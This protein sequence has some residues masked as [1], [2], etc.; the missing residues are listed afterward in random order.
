MNTYILFWLV[1]ACGFLLLE[2]TSPGLFYFLSFSCGALCAALAGGVCLTVFD[3]KVIF[4]VTSFGALFV[5]RRWVRM[6]LR[7]NHHVSNVFALQGKRGVVVKPATSEHF[8]YATIDSETWAF[9]MVHHQDHA[10]GQQI[11]VV[12]IKGAHLIVRPIDE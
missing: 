1:V 7:H 9:K 10:A 6:Q 12:A 8:G 5:L 11:E 3:Q 2:L 4:L